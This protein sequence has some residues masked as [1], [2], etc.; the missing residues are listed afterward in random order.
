[1]RNLKPVRMLVLAAVLGMVSG[2]TGC[3]SSQD[4]SSNTA[5]TAN[6]PAATLPSGAQASGA[7][8]TAKPQAAPTPPP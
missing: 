5:T 8:P 1:M 2:V 6:K 4:N 3:S 7:R